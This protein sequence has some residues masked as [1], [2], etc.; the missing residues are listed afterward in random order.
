M[1]NFTVSIRAILVVL[2]LYNL[3]SD[4]MWCFAMSSKYHERHNPEERNPRRCSDTVHADTSSMG[5]D[6]ND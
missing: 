2:K 4:H 6:Q 5:K 3:D 1:C